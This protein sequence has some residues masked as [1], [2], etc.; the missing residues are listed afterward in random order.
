MSLMS[1]AVKDLQMMDIEPPKGQSCRKYDTQCIRKEVSES[2]FDM[3][4]R[5][6]IDH[7][8]LFPASLERQG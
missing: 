4:F 3:L 8:F 6:I 1:I 5:L 7:D 2:K